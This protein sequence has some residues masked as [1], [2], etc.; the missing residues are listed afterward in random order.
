ML[1]RPYE[2]RRRAEERRGAFG[3]R[4][5]WS[6]VLPRPPPPPL[7]DLGKH[8]RCALGLGYDLAAGPVRPR[9]STLWLVCLF[10]AQ[11]VT[12]SLYI[13]LVSATRGSFFL[14]CSYIFS[15]S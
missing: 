1:P 9:R 15:G 3:R 6:E 13:I 8:T 10:S 12:R 4:V 14:P 7:L 11:R 5:L 2:V